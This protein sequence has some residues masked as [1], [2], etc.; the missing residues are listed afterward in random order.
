MGVG[1]ILLGA[2]SGEEC[3]VQDWVPIPCD[4]SRGP[5]FYLSQN[6]EMAL[7]SLLEFLAGQETQS[8]R[9]VV[10]W[11][12]AHPREEL[13]LL[14]E[15]VEIHQ[16]RFAGKLALTVK[17]DQFGA[18]QVA[19]HAGDES[20][21][22]VP[23]L[24]EP[25]FTFEPLPILRREAGQRR[26]MAP[27]PAPALAPIQAAPKPRP[28]P[29]DW[30]TPMVVMA[31]MLGVIL[32]GSLAARAYHAP[33]PISA[34]RV[35]AP[36]EMLSLHLEHRSG[37]LV[38]SWNG[39]AAPINVA[40]RVTLTL[41]DG[42]TTTRRVLSRADAK[43]GVQYF[44]R[45]SPSISANLV[46]ETPAGVLVTEDARLGEMAED[47]LPASRVTPD[48]FPPVARQAARF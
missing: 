10:G 34:P 26:R 46:L 19:V 11:F 32:M 44:R 24:V 4:H 9:Q 33:D 31:A 21:D 7:G 12:A 41:N 14:R 13:V 42:K 37:R 29:T 47:G 36:M 16:R 5:S 27:V 35:T 38:V 25:T 30:R 1:G 20:V 6:D 2:R 40:S 17:P 23:A 3:L 43:S 28:E 45:T 22:E 48:M 8:G 18:L 15:E 39:A